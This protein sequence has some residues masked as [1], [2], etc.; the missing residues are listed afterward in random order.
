MRCLGRPNMGRHNIFDRR[1]YAS[2]SF[3]KTRLDTTISKLQTSSI[4]PETRGWKFLSEHLRN[5]AGV[6]GSVQELFGRRS[7]HEEVTQNIQ[8]LKKNYL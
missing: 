8:K 3:R 7:E 5:F 4:S 1:I 6:C 2:H